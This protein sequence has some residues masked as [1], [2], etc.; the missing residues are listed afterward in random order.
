MHTTDL[1]GTMT[2]MG[3][4]TTG[5][6][7]GFLGVAGDFLRA[8]HVRNTVMLT[9]AETARLNPGRYGTRDDADPASLPLFGWWTD[10]PGRGAGVGGAIGA[11]FMHTPPSPVVLS[12]APPAAAADLAANTLAGRPL[13]GV[14]ANEETAAAFAAARRASTGCRVETH[15]R[16]RLYRLA[17]LTWPDPL[18]DGVPRTAGEGDVPLLTDWFTQFARE[19]DDLHDGDQ[20][21]DVRERLSYGGLTL[22]EAGGTPVCLAGVTRRVAGMVRVGPVY[23]PPPLRG[24]GYASAATAEVSRAARDAGAEE[25]LLYADLAN[26]VS[27][28]IYQRIGYREVADLVV[29]SFAGEGPFHGE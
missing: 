1:H 21:A 24:R 27:N 7:A 23:T 28:S 15:R 29:L 14:T 3:W 4:Q 13:A 17:G 19:V 5:D 9:V 18:P 8:E 16:M 10:G 20:T 11:A 2:P 25:V 12:V 6:V 26:P 22:W